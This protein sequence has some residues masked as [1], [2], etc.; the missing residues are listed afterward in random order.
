MAHFDYT[1]PGGVWSGS[2]IVTTAEIEDLDSKTERAING[3]E[4]GTWAPTDPIVIGGDGMEINGPLIADD[5]QQIDLTAGFIEAFSGTEIRVDSGATLI[6]SGDQNVESGG[7]INVKSGGEIE[8]RSGGLFEVLA[9][10]IV[11]IFGDM[12]IESGG[13]LEI[14]SGGGFATTAG[15]TVVLAADMVQSGKVTKTGSGGRTVLRSTTVT[16]LNSTPDITNDVWFITINDGNTY[17]ATLDVTTPAPATGEVVIVRKIGTSGQLNISSE[18]P[19]AICSIGPGEAGCA[20]LIFDG[21]QWRLVS[22][23]QSSDP[24]N[25]F[26]GA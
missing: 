2:V 19:I 23:W 21:T 4:G 11:D 5:V 12:D 22:M 9:G 1:R 3:D 14:K 25:I 24:A 15:A 20:T 17:S 18:G 7:N 26:S 13:S 8:V 16:N 6:L 10:G